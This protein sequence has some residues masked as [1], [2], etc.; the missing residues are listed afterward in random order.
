MVERMIH[1][2]A[3]AMTLTLLKLNVHRRQAVVENTLRPQWADFRK[4]WSEQR[5]ETLTMK[6]AL[7]NPNQL[8]HFLTYAFERD[9]SLIPRMEAMLARQEEA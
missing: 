8:Y 1:P 6:R 4:H 9:K 2:D 7:S 3:R 5:Q